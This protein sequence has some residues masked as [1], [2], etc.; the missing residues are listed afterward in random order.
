MTVQYTKPPDSDQIEVSLFGPGYGECIVLHV[1]NGAWI[2]VDSCIDQDDNPVALKYLNEIGIELAQNVNLIVATHWHDDHIRG[3]GRL[4]TACCE[5]DFCCANAL[6]QKEFINLVGALERRPATK[7]GS[8]TREIYEV[9]TQLSKIK[10]SA[11]YA[12]TNRLIYSNNF[13]K[14]WSLSPSDSVFQ[15][16][17]RNVSQLIPREGK[18]KVRIPSLTPNQTAVVLLVEFNNTSVLLGS[19]LENPGWNV[20]LNSPVRSQDRS[21]VFKVP[22]HGSRNAD[23]PEVWEEMLESEPYSILTPWRRGGNSLPNADDVS[24][25]LRHT[26][27]AYSTARNTRGKS[28]SRDSAVE[29]TIR[30]SGIQLNPIT[31]ST[32]TIRLRKRIV[33]DTSWNVELFGSACKLENM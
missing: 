5:A 10:K 1:G 20:I 15:D 14:I 7:S 4:V 25:I 8:G 30:E 17:L 21:A 23:L 22:H 24:R 33:H 31:F 26:T 6:T 18:T 19:D 2:I 32:G 3:L 12:V 28:L 16:F 29:K 27:R 9:F 11:I 13:C